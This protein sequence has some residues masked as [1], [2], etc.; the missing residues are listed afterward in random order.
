MQVLRDLRGSV[1]TRGRYRVSLSTLRA[2]R[3][4]GDD[5]GRGL[6]RCVHPVPG[7]LAPWRPMMIQCGLRQ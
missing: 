3:L 2:L 5:F 7:A 6:P 4:C 1:F